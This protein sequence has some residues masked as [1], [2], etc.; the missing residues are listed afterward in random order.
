[1][2][3]TKPRDTPTR[4]PSSNPAA[5]PLNLR[6]SRAPPP[7]P[8]PTQPA[9]P[10]P[11]LWR[12]P[13]VVFLSLALGMLALAALAPTVRFPPW[14]LVARRRLPQ[15]RTPGRCAGRSARR[16]SGGGT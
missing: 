10:T 8:H 2:Q 13:P 11:A 12:E 14:P 9:V 6:V 1:L 5:S 16:R 4:Q 3:L 15:F 7:T